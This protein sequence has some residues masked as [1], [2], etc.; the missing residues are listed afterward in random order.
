MS[1]ESQRA[2]PDEISAVQQTR[3]QSQDEIN[4][5][6]WNRSINWSG[7]YS[8]KLDSRLWVPKRGIRGT[9]YALN[10]GHP[11]AKTIIGGLLIVPVAVALT[12]VLL[13]FFG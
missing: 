10:F 12:L 5:E 1:R 7:G 3:V 11:G 9:G 4:E 6:E 2:T 13:K 8:S